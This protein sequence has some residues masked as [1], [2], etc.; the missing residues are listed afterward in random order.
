MSEIVPLARLG[1]NVELRGWRNERAGDLH[2][3]RVADVGADRDGQT[4]E[5]CRGADLECA[6]SRME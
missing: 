6:R 3:E 5:R 1:L 4:V 2:G